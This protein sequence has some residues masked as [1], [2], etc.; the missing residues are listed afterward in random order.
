MC[1]GSQA[2]VGRAMMLLIRRGAAQELI[3]V[4]VGDLGLGALRS[5]L[6]LRP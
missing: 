3:D 6:R 5:D 1:E 4:D 2:I